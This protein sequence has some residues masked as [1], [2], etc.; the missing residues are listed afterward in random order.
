[1]TEEKVFYDLDIPKG[2]HKKLIKD[3]K[4]CA[5]HAG[6]SPH[7]VGRRAIGDNHLLDRL[8]EGKS[9]KLSTLEVLYAWMRN[10]NRKENNNDG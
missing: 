8:L 3:I 10:V 6:I 2:A 5:T 9:I 7:S 4:R 1:M